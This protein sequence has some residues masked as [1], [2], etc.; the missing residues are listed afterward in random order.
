MDQ[1]DVSLDRTLKKPPQVHTVHIV[2]ILVVAMVQFMIE[3][4]TDF[5]SHSLVTHSI[6]RNLY[7]NQSLQQ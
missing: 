4:Q 5:V 1:F 3:V 2:Q 7:A 6:N